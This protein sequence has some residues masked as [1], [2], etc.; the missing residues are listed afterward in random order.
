MSVNTDQDRDGLTYRDA[1][2]D[3]AAADA[4]VARLRSLAAA[5]HGPAVRPHTEAYA[6]LYELSSGPLLAATCDGVGTKLL[7]GQALGR[8]RGLGQDLV[9]M[10]VNDLLPCGARPLFFLDYVAT[11]RLDGTALCELVAGMADACRAVGCAL[12]G[13]ETAEMPGVYGPGGLDLA[14]FAVG[15]AA[16]ER[17]PQRQ[18]MA[19]KDRVLGL[20]SAG[21]HSNGLSLARRALDQA[22]IGLDVMLPEL[23]SSPGEVLLAPTALY[24]AAVLAAFDRVGGAAGHI[25]AAAHVTG[26][27]LLGRAAAMAPAGLRLRIDPSTYPRPPIFDVLARAGA[28]S[29]REMA[30]TFNMG[31][32]FL[33]VT[34]PAAA[35]TLLAAP[36]SPWLDVGEVVAGDTGVD[37]GYA[38]SDA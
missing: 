38:K 3:I 23:G 4:L 37:L 9:A 22:G 20:A 6:G 13:G 10:N 32:G 29:P 31:L 5:T 16:P 24:V 34:S 33:L 30:R 2:V 36:D 1:G 25:R 28:I 12:L 15:L 35:K 14:G 8:Y 7:I 11:G 26:G 18:A 19:P 27:G 21:V 17:L